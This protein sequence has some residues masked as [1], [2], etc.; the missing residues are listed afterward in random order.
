V[1]V[2]RAVLPHAVPMAFVFAL[3]GCVT[4]PT[5]PAVDRPA[6]N[7]AILTQPDG[8]HRSVERAE[9]LDQGSLIRSPQVAG[10]L[11]VG[12]ASGDQLH[13]YVFSIGQAD[14][15]LIVG[16]APERRSL[17][18][19]LGEV[20]WNSCAPHL[21][22]PNP[23]ARKLLITRVRE[24]PIPFTHAPANTRGAIRRVLLWREP[25]ESL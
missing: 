5:G 17:L 13:I 16:P 19:D 4:A 7:P 10:A 20:S 2:P 12:A 22:L 8:D 3:A 24:P 11:S 18:I 15:M 25:S 1:P 6:P 9:G 21:F 14:S 23:A